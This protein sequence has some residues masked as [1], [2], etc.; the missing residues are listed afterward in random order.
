MYMVDNM[1]SFSA[2]LKVQ[3]SV[4]LMHGFLSKFLS[5]I[6][7]VTEMHVDGFRFD[8]A[9]ILT[10]STSSWDAVN[11]YGN[12][13]DGDVITT[14]TPLTSPPLVDMISN[15]PIL[16]G[17]KLIAEAWDCGGLYQVGMFPHWGIWSE[18]NGKK[19]NR[20]SWHEEEMHFIL[21]R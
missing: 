6:Y 19:I 10:R 3:I 18:W 5:C 20:K 16:R 1:M 4:F 9:S 11:V 15:D 2:I 7:W 21:C 8:L 13:T 12:S 14:G 17:V